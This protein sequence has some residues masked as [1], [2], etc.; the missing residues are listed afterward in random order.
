MREDCRTPNHFLTLG[1]T[2]VNRYRVGVGEDMRQEAASEVYRE[3]RGLRQGGK[4]CTYGSSRDSLGRN[5]VVRGK[6]NLQKPVVIG[7]RVQNAKNS[8]RLPHLLSL[9]RERERGES[10]E[11]AQ[12]QKRLTVGELVAQRSGEGGC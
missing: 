5:S 11:V 8:Q 1:P 7:L 10:Q 12:T 2:S 6:K 4:I 9:S 3:S